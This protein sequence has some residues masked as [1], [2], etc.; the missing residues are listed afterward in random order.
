MPNTPIKTYR[1]LVVW[2]KAMN[3]G[4]AVHRFCDERR[5]PRFFVLLDQLQRAAGSVPSNIAEGY[6]RR[7]RGDY[8]R[9]VSIANGSL[10]ELETHL[11]LAGRIEPGWRD[12][13]DG[14]LEMSPEVGRML[15]GLHRAL[16]N[17]PAKP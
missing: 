15:I 8:M 13:V 5:T 16:K 6:G 2:D 10:C 3:L 1:D 14:M 7:S 4:V 17:G 12:P 9:F 11:L